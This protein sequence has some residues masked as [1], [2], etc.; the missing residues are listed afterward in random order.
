W[1]NDG[2]VQF[3]DDIYQRDGFGASGAVAS[4]PVQSQNGGILEPMALSQ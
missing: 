2:V 1:A 4:A 3:R